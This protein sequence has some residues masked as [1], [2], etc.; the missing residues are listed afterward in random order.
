MSN[1][2]LSRCDFVVGHRQTKTQYN[3]LRFHI[4]GVFLQLDSHAGVSYNL[5]QGGKKQLVWE[6][7]GNFAEE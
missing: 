2:Q 4:K 6:K 7:Q 3:V 5:S 1:Y